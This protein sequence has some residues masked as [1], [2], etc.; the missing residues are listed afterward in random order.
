[1]VARFPNFD[2]FLAD[3]QAALNIRFQADVNE[4]SLLR[5]EIGF[6]SLELFEFVIWLDD[7]LDVPLSTEE[8]NGLRTLGD[9]HSL[10]VTRS[11][12]LE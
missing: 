8:L 6:D 12:V 9:A 2:R 5:T 3:I 4:D 7:R 10:V 1:M 11:I